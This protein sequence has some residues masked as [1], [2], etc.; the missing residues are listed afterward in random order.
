[1]FRKL[2]D[3]HIDIRAPG[4]GSFR[5]CNPWQ[6]YKLLVGAKTH[7]ERRGIVEASFGLVEKLSPRQGAIAIQLIV[8][9]CERA[10]EVYDSVAEDSEI[11]SFFPQITPEHLAKMDDLYRLALLAHGNRIYHRKRMDSMA[12]INAVLA[13]KDGGRHRAALAEVAY[14][15]DEKQLLRELEVLSRT[16]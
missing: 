14:Q 2:E 1:M 7:Q 6:V 11:M 13:G 16:K 15:N 10:S 8:A 4:G 3:P 12:D 9:Y 5:R